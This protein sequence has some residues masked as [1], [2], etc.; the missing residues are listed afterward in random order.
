MV[1]GSVS[2]Q[3]KKGYGGCGPTTRRYW[4]LLL[5]IKT[6]HRRPQMALENNL[7][8]HPRE[9]GRGSAKSHIFN[10]DRGDEEDLLLPS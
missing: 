5:G 6:S 3:I 2:H 4:Y 10:R 1:K 9:G 7:W 8:Q